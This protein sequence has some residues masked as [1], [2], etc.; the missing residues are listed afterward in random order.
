M[1]IY[2]AV[3]NSCSMWGLSCACGVL[4]VQC[5]IQPPDQGSN[6]GALHWDHGVLATGTREVPRLQVLVQLSSTYFRLPQF[7][8]EST[9]LRGQS[10]VSHPAQFSSSHFGFS[11][12][13][14]S[15]VLFLCPNWHMSVSHVPLYSVF[16]HSYLHILPRQFYP[17]P[18]HQLPCRFW[19]TLYATSL[20]RFLFGWFW[21]AR[22]ILEFHSWVPKSGSCPFPDVGIISDLSSLSCCAIISGDLQFAP[23]GYLLPLSAF[24]A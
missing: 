4:V 9:P 1:Y 15:R 16:C 8:L 24:L 14:F 6:P 2:F 22:K 21:I 13:G 11:S 18:W 7:P 19:K 5:E 20:Q 23:G 3:R 10:L 17:L 12:A